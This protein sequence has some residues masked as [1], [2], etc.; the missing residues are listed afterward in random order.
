MAETPGG[1]LWLSNLDLLLPSTYH[2]HAIYFYR[3]NGAA[4]FFDSTLLKAALS[5]ALVEFYPYA[6]RLGRREDNR[7]EINCNG[8]GLLFVEAECDATVADFGDFTPK[9]ELRLIPAINMKNLVQLTRFKC[10]GVS[11]GVANEHHLSDGVSA[12]H[13]FNS[14]ADIARG[15]PIGIPPFFDRTLL[16]ARDFPRPHFPHVEYQP[17]PPLTTPLD[18]N[19]E[20]TFSIFKLRRDQLN[21]LKAKC[22]EDEDGKMLSYSTYEVVTGHVWRCVCMARGLPGDQ[23]TKLHMPVD[24]RS[25]LRPQL[26]SGYF[27]NVIFS[28]TPIALCGELASKPLRFAVGKVHEAIARLDDEYLRS[29]LDHLELLGDVSAF[30]RGT[31][32]TK[33]PNLGIIS[34]V[35]LPVYDADFGWGNPV[36]SGPGVPPYEGKSYLLRSPQN[37]GSLLYG[38]TLLKQHMTLFEK[39]LYDAI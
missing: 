28:A 24:G 1:T 31:H 36:Y 38:V 13:F 5:R 25:R 9:V 29:A 18:N 12:L 20:T 37:D 16:A 30:A 33:C 27:G 35:R 15:Q 21:A 4:N 26:P 17:P 32:T 22:K 10:G 23:E 7:L 39:M 6:G 11:L 8:A 14:W 19:S 34:W 2:T 3:S